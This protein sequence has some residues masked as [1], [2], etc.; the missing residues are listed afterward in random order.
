LKPYCTEAEFL[1]T[2]ATPL[3]TAIIIVDSI[4]ENL[5]SKSGSEADENKQLVDLMSTLEQI[6]SLIRNRRELLPKPV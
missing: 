1:H 3:A 4:Q 6:R 5:K 2:M